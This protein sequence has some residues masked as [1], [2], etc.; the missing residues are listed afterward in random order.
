MTE[1]YP[2]GKPAW[3]SECFDPGLGLR[4]SIRWEEDF[5]SQYEAQERA[6]DLAFELGTLP[7]LGNWTNPCDEDRLD[8]P[9]MRP[10]KK[11]PSTLF[12]VHFAEDVQIYFGPEDAHQMF[13]LKLH[14][15]ALTAWHAKPC[16]KFAKPWVWAKEVYKMIHQLRTLTWR[17]QEPQSEVA[18]L[19][20]QNPCHKQHRLTDSWHQPLPPEWQGMEDAPEPDPDVIPD[21]TFAPAFVHDTF[22][23]ADAHRAFT[24]L[25]SDGAMRIRSWYVHHGTLRSNL[26]PRFLEFEEDWRHWEND[27]MGAWRDLIQPDQEV[28]IH[29]VKPDPYRG[30]LSREVHAD[31]IVSQGYWLHRLPALITVHQPT[32]E[33]TAVIVCS[34]LLVD[35]TSWRCSSGGSC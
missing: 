9:F 30:Y 16:G 15:S 21:P 33:F 27:L 17:S 18:V 1:L 25:D 12:T 22:E 24:D 5:T 2:C 3:S 32:E 19:I 13:E 26:H 29:V 8:G 6:S 4:H 7:I 28:R 20:R 10:T 11:R 34:S 31:I 35:A 23:L 14:S